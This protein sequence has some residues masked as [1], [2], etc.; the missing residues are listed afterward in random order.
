MELTDR[1]VDRAVEVLLRRLL[2][3]QVKEVTEEPEEPPLIS[4]Q[5]AAVALEV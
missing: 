4:L 5:A 3:P 2:E 1:Q